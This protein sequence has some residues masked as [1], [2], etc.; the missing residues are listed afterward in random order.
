MKVELLNATEKEIPFFLFTIEGHGF[1]YH[2]IRKMIGLIIQFKNQKISREDFI[3][4]F[5]KKIID[6]WLAPSSGLFLK[7]VSLIKEISL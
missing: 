6:I 3:S 7:E 4:V 2:Q 1:M 5:E